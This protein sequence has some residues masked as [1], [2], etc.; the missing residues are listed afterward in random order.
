MEEFVDWIEIRERKDID[1]LLERFDH[2]H[3]SCLKE[4]YLWTEAFVDS[5]LAMHMSDERD[6]K[7]RFLFQRQWKGPSA[8]EL[9]F[10]GV[11]TF[12]LAPRAANEDSLIYEA[13][14]YFRNGLFYWAEDGDW[15]YEEKERFPNVSWISSE[16]LKWRDASSWMGKRNRY[17]VIL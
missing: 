8:I 9:L 7:A 17:G 2:F 12:H 10:G 16:K 5:D 15:I 14:L 11:T 13:Q 1:H 3:D 4:S 6:T